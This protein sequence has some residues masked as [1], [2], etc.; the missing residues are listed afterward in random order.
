MQSSHQQ[1]LRGL[2]ADP[3]NWITLD[4]AMQSLGHTQLTVL[5]ADIE[6]AEYDVLGFWS[7]NATNLPLQ[8][9]VELHVEWLYHGMLLHCKRPEGIYVLLFW[10]S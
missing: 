7:L 6:G 10:W 1:S 2:Q 9:A 5:K 4:A 8:I 3:Q